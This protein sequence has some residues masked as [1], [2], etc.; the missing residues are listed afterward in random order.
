[1]R[2]VRVLV[3]CTANISRSP[4]FALMLRSGTGSI[5][6]WES[7][8]VEVTSAGIE[9]FVNPGLDSRMVAALRRA[10]LELY[11]EGGRRLDDVDVARADLILTATR[12]QRAAVVRRNV[13]ARESCFTMREFARYCAVAPRVPDTREPSRA[14]VD[15]VRFA[16][17]QRG[18]L[19][20]RAPRDDDVPDP[21]GSGR[22]TYRRA[23]GLMLDAAGTILAASP[24]N[25]SPS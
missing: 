3:V 7:R 22:R 6:G 18:S 20:P 25:H 12:E 10:G 14:V 15:L 4:A 24:A 11:G 8:G 19:Y 16:Q 5:P 23:V 2:S 13:F 1:M 21:Y 17:S 9:G